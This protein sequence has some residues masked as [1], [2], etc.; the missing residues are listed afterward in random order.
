M[1]TMAR[2]VLR[3]M[4]AG[5]E[6]LDPE[7]FPALLPEVRRPWRRGYRVGTVRFD[8]EAEATSCAEKYGS[9]VR[10]LRIR[11]VPRGTTI[12]REV[13]AM[14]AV[15][16]TLVPAWDDMERRRRTARSQFTG[17]SMYGG[18]AAWLPRSDS[19]GGERFT[20]ST[21]FQYA[22]ASP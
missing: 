21:G 9:R 19:F 16:L 1:A 6:S 4:Y 11:R 15:E 5:P 22:E 2:D 12:M 7:A 8:D 10:K 20:L 13:L 3:K 18:L 14:L 17:R